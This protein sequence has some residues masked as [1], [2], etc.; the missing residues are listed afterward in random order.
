MYCTS[1]PDRVAI[2]LMPTAHTPAVR[3]NSL[4]GGEIL[5]LTKKTK[6][7]N[8]VVTTAIPFE[9]KQWWCKCFVCF[10]VWCTL[11]LLRNKG[12]SGWYDFSPLS[13]R[14]V[15]LRFPPPF[16]L[17]FICPSCTWAHTRSHQS[18][19][20]CVYVCFQRG[21]GL[22]SGVSVSACVS[23]AACDPQVLDSDGPRPAPGSP[24]TS[25][26]HT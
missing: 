12:N 17:F 1:P 24:L 15:P 16:F 5:N 6:K 7:K 22:V 25:R 11:L 19:E 13:L 21:L 10:L 26:T 18:C 4:S 20:V 8:L 23:A 14:S 9:V 2:Q 3:K